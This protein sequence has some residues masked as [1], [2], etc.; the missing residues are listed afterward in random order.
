MSRLISN[1]YK[2]VAS[3]LRYHTMN[4]RLLKSS[5]SYEARYG[6]LS[7]VIADYQDLNCPEKVKEVLQV[8]EEG[9][10]F[11]IMVDK[12]YYNY[13]NFKLHEEPNLTAVNNM[14]RGYVLPSA[15]A[16]TLG[17]LVAEIAYRKQLK[18]EYLELE[19]ELSAGSAM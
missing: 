16:A 19:K 1:A 8:L 9:K 6:E 12:L 14:L 13:K 3:G 5:Y 15:V 18:E 4:Q 17:I 2:S 7:K 11:R 10:E